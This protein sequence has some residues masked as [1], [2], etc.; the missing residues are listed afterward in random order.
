M[1]KM[2]SVF[3]GVSARRTESI[4]K[5]IGDERSKRFLLWNLNGKVPRLAH[6]LVGMMSKAN[7]IRH[8]ASDRELQQECNRST[9]SP[10]P[11]RLP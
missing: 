3:S 8:L 11:D 5:S 10:L 7:E 4:H 9:Y 2:V 1:K 6:L